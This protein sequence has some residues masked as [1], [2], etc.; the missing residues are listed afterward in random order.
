MSESNT[1]VDIKQGWQTGVSN[2]M[3]GEGLEL[4]YKRAALEAK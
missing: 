2:D 1:R 4:D 3:P